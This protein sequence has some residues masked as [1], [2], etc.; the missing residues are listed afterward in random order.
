[1]HLARQ[2]EENIEQVQ[3]ASY[4]LSSSDGFA[5]NVLGFE[6]F[7]GDR[8]IVIALESTAGNGEL[9]VRFPVRIETALTLLLHSIRTKTQYRQP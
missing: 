9:E 5:L 1:M 3:R 4:R 8:E 7:N 2:I 6:L